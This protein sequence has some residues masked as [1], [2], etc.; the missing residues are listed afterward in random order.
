M[1]R[2]HEIL[3]LAASLGRLASR[4]QIRTITKQLRCSHRRTWT[5]TFNGVRCFSQQD[6][7]VSLG[8]QV[9]TITSPWSEDTP[10]KEV[11]AAFNLKLRECHSP[12]DVLDLVHQCNLASWSISNGLA[13]MWQTTKKMSDEQRRCELKLMTE[14]PTFERLCHRARTNAPRMLS[15]DLAFTLL[16]LVKLG[17]SQNS[18][19]VQTV[20]RV[21]Q[22]T[23]TLTHRRAEVGIA[24]YNQLQYLLQ[25]I[26]KSIKK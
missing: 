6:S 21:I 16:G 19:V 24:K 22:V 14:H 25:N 17:V 2:S 11:R 20:L 18:F 15:H 7:D 26:S 3:R 4:S 5:F 12:S 10:K 1:L 13:H 23:H 9:P 8:L